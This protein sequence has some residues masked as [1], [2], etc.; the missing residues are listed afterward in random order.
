MVSNQIPKDCTLVQYRANYASAVLY[1][2]LK[3]WVKFSY[4]AA[5]VGVV[6]ALVLNPV[7]PVF[8]LVMLGLSRV[9]VGKSRNRSCALALIIGGVVMTTLA[10][11]SGLCWLICGVSMLRV[12]KKIDAEYEELMAVMRA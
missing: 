8:S 6:L 3:L 5:V 7:E 11:L 9:G 10:M 2:Q 12:F 1:A 4:A